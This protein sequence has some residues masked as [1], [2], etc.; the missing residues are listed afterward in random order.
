MNDLKI[1]LDVSMLNHSTLIVNGVIYQVS[2]IEPLVVYPNQEEPGYIESLEI[3]DGFHQIKI[4][5]YEIYLKRTGIIPVIHHWL[6]GGQYKIV[7]A[8]I[9]HGRWSGFSNPML[10]GINLT[11]QGLERVIMD[12]FGDAYI[13]YRPRNFNMDSVLGKGDDHYDRIDVKTLKI[14]RL[15][16]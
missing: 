16:N 6:T 12:I 3:L 8:E 1:V 10:T 9:S 2:G 4:R 14:K 11:G 13:E 15:F 5:F 7:I